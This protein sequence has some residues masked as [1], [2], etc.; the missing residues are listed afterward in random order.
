MPES[1][2]LYKRS[3]ALREQTYGA[4]DSRVAASLRN[5]AILLR[6]MGKDS[7]AG[8]LDARAETIEANPDNKVDIN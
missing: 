4:N 1:E 3:L 7:E 8:K 6:K 5:Y 2:Q